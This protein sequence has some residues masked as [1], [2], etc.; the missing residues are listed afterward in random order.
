MWQRRPSPGSTLDQRALFELLGTLAFT[1]L[2]TW[3]FVWAS[4]H[5]NGLAVTRYVNGGYSARPAHP[6]LAHW[7]SVAARAVAL[8]GGG[9]AVYRSPLFVTKG[10]EQLLW[11]GIV[12]ATGCAF[13]AAVLYLVYWWPTHLSFAVLRFFIDTRSSDQWTQF[14]LWLVPF[15]AAV[16]AVAGVARTGL[17]RAGRARRAVVGSL[18]VIAFLNFPIV[19]H[20]HLMT[21]KA[22]RSTGHRAGGDA[23]AWHVLRA[24]PI[25]VGIIRPYRLSYD[26]A[27]ENA[28]WAELRVGWFGPGLG[29]AWVSSMCDNTI[30]L[31]C[32]GGGPTSIRSD[33]EVWR[34]RSGSFRLFAPLEAYEGYGGTLPFLGYTFVPAVKWFGLAFWLLLGSFLAVRSPRVARMAT[35]VSRARGGPG[36]ERQPASP[37]APS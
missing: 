7:S 11:L 35:W 31:P 28:P 12:F 8:I 6:H 20:P 21:E 16:V 30:L 9:L 19:P 25:P 1:L 4:R 2:L 22:F 18:A 5:F 26:Y 32:W 29:S 10:P 3:L 36:A 14:W 23:G 24:G 13:V 17:P 15:V 34:S 27:G 33:L 37:S